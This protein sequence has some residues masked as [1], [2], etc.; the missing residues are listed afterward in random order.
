MRGVKLGKLV[1]LV[2]VICG[3][4]TGEGSAIDSDLKLL[5]TLTQESL[6]ATNDWASLEIRQDVS[7][8]AGIRVGNLPGFNLTRPVYVEY[9]WSNTWGPLAYGIGSEQYNVYDVDQVADPVQNWRI[10]PPT[11]A[12]ETPT[13]EVWPTPATSATIRFTGQQRVLDFVSDEDVCTVD[14]LLLVYY[15]AVDRLA[16]L[17]KKSS[18]LML[19]KANA[20][21][22]SLRSVEHRS[23][24]S[25]S[26]TS[27]ADQA[28][29]RRKTVPILSV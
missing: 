11:V 2:K 22:A 7:L 21:A 18:S 4:S 27:Y 6:A 24:N 8:A 15:A 20:L 14:H 28:E 26:F 9:Q 10:I 3:D 12:D 5:L 17:N 19:A 16:L 29:P 13:F 25:I 23:G 1:Q